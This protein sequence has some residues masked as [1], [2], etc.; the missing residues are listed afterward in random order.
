M[1]SVCVALALCVS[2]RVV[3]SRRMMYEFMY[4]GDWSW[5]DKLF[6]I[7]SWKR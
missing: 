5:V 6:C 4:S 2:G 1:I 3:Q 7:Q